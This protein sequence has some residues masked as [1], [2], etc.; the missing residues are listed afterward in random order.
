[1]SDRWLIKG[2]GIKINRPLELYTKLKE[3]AALIP[4]KIVE[5]MA[6]D[7]V[8]VEG[9]E[10]IEYRRNGHPSVII[11]GGDFVIVTPSGELIVTLRPM[12]EVLNLGELMRGY[13][14]VGMDVLDWTGA[15]EAH[16]HHWLST[17]PHVDAE[18][19]FRNGRA[20]KMRLFT[21]YHYNALSRSWQEAEYG[22]YLVSFGDHHAFSLPCGDVQRPEPATLKYS[23]MGYWRHNE[24]ML[25][26]GT[27]RI[28]RM[29]FDTDPSDEF[30]QMVYDEICR[31]MNLPAQA[32]K[33]VA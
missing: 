3:S 22:G 30:K 16:V 23:D 19:Q 14:C 5:Q 2:V 27:M 1:M 15:T 28:G 24:G 17:H 29:D 12:Y 6:D 20:E 10:C 4:K 13:C 21:S 32:S 8:S 11:K 33:T 9:N 25:F 31:R 26:C 18:P 7:L